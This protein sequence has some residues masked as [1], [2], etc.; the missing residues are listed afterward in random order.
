MTASVEWLDVVDENDRIIDHAPRAEVHAQGLRHRS[1]HVLLRNRQGH[2]FLQRRSFIKDT[3]PGCWDSSASG[4]VEAGEDYETAMKRELQEEIGWSPAPDETFPERILRLPAQPLTGAEFVWVYAGITEG[5]FHLNPHEIIEG[6]WLP[7]AEITSW[8][9]RD[10]A[11][12]ADSF[13]LIWG[14]I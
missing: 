14:M 2:V 4:H 10:P 6:R 13:R 1:V 7:P 11:T 5:P 12:F 3:F 9:K 8:I